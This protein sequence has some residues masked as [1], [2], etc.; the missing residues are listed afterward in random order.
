MEET[1]L[2]PPGPAPLCQS[3]QHG[4]LEL[5]EQQFVGALLVDRDARVQ[6]ITAR[7]AA[8]LGLDDPADAL[9]R[10]VE[11]ILPHSRMREV[12]QSGEPIVLDFMNY[13]Q[14]HFVVSRFPLQ[15]G[16]GQV[17]G[18]FGI[19]LS[20]RWQP[21]K[22]LVDKLSQLQETLDRVRRDNA[23]SRRARYGFDDII[24]AGA[25]CR[26][27]QR[28]GQRA[29]ALDTTVLLLGETGTG[30]E[31]LA[32]AIHAASPRRQKPFV[33]LNVAA[34]PE[35]L[36]EAEFFGAVAG[37]YT[38]AE[39]KGRDG[40]FKL[41]DGGTLFLDEIGDMS[42]PMQAKL[43]RVLQEQEIEP[44]G[45]NRLLHIDV[46]VIAATSR[47]LRALVD[48]GLF[49]ADLFYRLNVLPIRLPPL[50][51]R[52]EDLPAL[53]DSLLAQIADRTGLPQRKPGAAALALLAT[54]PWPGNIRELRNVLEQAVMLSDG[55]ALDAPVLQRI[56][57]V[58]AAVDPPPL[59]GGGTLAQR[60]AETERRVISETLALAGGNKTEAARALGI[61]RATLYE[62]LADPRLFPAQT[63]PSL[64]GLVR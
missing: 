36:L 47:D 29:A 9:N 53:V 27:M 56:L 60:L 40:K 1:E 14:H 37:A 45:S 49:R 25:A 32:N 38:G 31:L 8:L 6:W 15:D 59:A 55:V 24:G 4:L 11:D 62:K 63:G 58:A 3:L 26:D 33:G 10:P 39:R 17:V 43:L 2:N 42:L 48:A 21:L 57:P 44:L 51:E 12:V 13:K 28:L 54:Y 18:A 61:S 22:P 20:E 7:Y 19:L 52:S 64:A 50:R 30:K 35:T 5:F 23:G 34:V 46:R 41:A 16:D